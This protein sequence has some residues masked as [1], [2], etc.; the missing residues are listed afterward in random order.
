MASTT[1]KTTIKAFAL[2]AITMAMALIAL[3]SI[4][5]TNKKH[6]QYHIKEEGNNNNNALLPP[7]KKIS[8]FLV[9]NDNYQQH[10]RSLKPADHCHKDN[11][12]CDV[13]YGKNFTCCGNK[14]FDLTI[15]KKHCGACHNKC[16]FT[17]DCCNGKCVDKNFDKRHCGRC[18]NKCLVGQY[19]VYG[20]CDYA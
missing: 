11:E 7:S 6:E 13:M 19:C 17:Y 9:E 12:V 5:V 4:S 16:K 2:V 15:D 18:N 14:C 10:G 20:M 1:M 3:S 8:R